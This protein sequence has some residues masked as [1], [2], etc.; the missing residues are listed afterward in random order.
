MNLEN[1]QVSFTS[2]KANKMRTLLTTLGIIIGVMSIILLVSIVAG[3]QDYV[4]SE[5]K[6]IGTNTFMI[7]PGNNEEMHGPPGT[8]AINKLK[9]SMIGLL[10]T[11]STYGAKAIP[12]YINM[13]ALVKYRNK[14]TNTTMLAGTTEKFPEVRN[15]YVAT[16]RFFRRE[17][18][19]SARKV[20]VVGQTIV[21]NFFHGANPIGRTRT[22]WWR[23]P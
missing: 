12:V 19:D 22:T 23:Y 3:T 13:G 9:M 17:D 8:F 2:L 21:N 10:E 1:F 5:I 15:W 16:G 7:A 6:S 11:R 14:S 4:E 20:C 18:V